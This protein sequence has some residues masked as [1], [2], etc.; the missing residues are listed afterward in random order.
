VE[1]PDASEA[2]YVV[3]GADPDVGILLRDPAEA[4]KDFLVEPGLWLRNIF[5]PLLFRKVRIDSGWLAWNGGA[6]RKLAEAAYAERSLPAGTLDAGRLA[7]LAGALE[8]AGSGEPE[9]LGHC[10]QQGMV[11]VRGC[12]V[13]DLL[14]DKG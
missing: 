7:V 12:W 1:L 6:V 4:A 2:A 10:R 3:F 5:G 13:V 9:I 8:E 11:H 14:L